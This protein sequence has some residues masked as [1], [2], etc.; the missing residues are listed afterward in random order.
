MALSLFINMTQRYLAEHRELLADTECRTSLLQSLDF[1][2]AAGW[3][4]AR[5]LVYRL[6]EA[7]R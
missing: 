4:T 6:D 7:F 1:F 3:P 5:R 2:V